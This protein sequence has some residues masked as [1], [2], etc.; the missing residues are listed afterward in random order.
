[1][2]TP[3]LF[4]LSSCVKCGFAKESLEEA[5]IE[6]REIELSPLQKQWTPTQWHLVNK[7]DVKDDIEKTAPVL[8][9]SEDDHYIGCL[10]IRQYARY[11]KRK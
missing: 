6:Y 7:Y 3:I 5:G 9:V 4:T 1:M 8:A 11:H 2:E 10:A